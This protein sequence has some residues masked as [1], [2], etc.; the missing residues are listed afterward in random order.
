MKNQLVHKNGLICLIYKKKNCKKCDKNNNNNNYNNNND[1]WLTLI[2]IMITMN[3]FIKIDRTIYCVFDNNVNRL[4]YISFS[5]QHFCSHKFSKL[6]L[7]GVSAVFVGENTDYYN[8]I[9]LV[10]IIF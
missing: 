7:D 5:C 2:L 8:K 9:E 1:K 3:T 10:A 6:M 4:M